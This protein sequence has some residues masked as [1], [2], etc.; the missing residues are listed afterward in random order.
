MNPGKGIRV[1][2]SKLRGFS[3]KVSAGMETGSSDWYF[4][5]NS[6]KFLKKE[7]TENVPES[8]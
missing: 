6:C 2:Y 5:L 1:Y 8:V 7:D 3:E 4:F